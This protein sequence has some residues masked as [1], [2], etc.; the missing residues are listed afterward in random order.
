MGDGAERSGVL[1]ESKAATELTGLAT[2][3]VAVGVGVRSTCGEKR[4]R[5]GLDV[6]R[7]LECSRDALLVTKLTLP[8]MGEADLRSGAVAAT[9]GD[10]AA[11]GVLVKIVISG[12]CPA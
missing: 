7:C 1:L 2:F 8:S 9:R 11:D 5:R 6:L 10:R 4:R 12:G 3:S